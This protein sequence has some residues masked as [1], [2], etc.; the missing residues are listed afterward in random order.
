MVKTMDIVNGVC[1]VIAAAYPGTP[2]YIEYVMKEFERPSFLVEHISTTKTAQTR[3]TV[4]KVVRLTC[5]CFTPID[6]YGNCDQEALLKRQADMDA[7]F[8]RGK[9]TVGDRELTVQSST[10]GSNI[11]EAYVELDIEFAD[12]RAE[13]KNT[14]DE[15][16]TVKIRTEVR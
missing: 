15:M 3:G 2:I 6:Q 16:E 8:D 4:A 1:A 11:G 7:L 9:V 14:Y 5:T 12:D 10:A 13:T